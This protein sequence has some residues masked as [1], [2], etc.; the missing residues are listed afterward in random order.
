MRDFFNPALPASRK[1]LSVFRVSRLDLFF[2]E[3]MLTI[4]ALNVHTCDRL[5]G[6]PAPHL[7]LL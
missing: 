1:P 6:R 2:D 5:I 7:V 4:Q 3:L